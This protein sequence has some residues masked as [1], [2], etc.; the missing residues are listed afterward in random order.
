MGALPHQLYVQ[1]QVTWTCET[2][3]KAVQPWDYHPDMTSRPLHKN[4]WCRTPLSPPGTTQPPKGR[5]LPAPR[6]GMNRFRPFGLRLTH[7]P[8]LPEEIIAP[9][10]R[11]RQARATCCVLPSINRCQ[12]KSLR[13]FFTFFENLSLAAVFDIQTVP[14]GPTIGLNLCF[15]SGYISNSL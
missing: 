2:V 1:P 5:P 4:R 13:T 7:A 8:Q 9:H 12:R 6:H 11:L 15:I 3:L 10:S 14:S